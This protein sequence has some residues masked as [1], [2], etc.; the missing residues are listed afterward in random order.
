VASPAI[1]TE[2]P[3]TSKNASKKNKKKDKK[4]VLLEAG[5]EEVG[6]SQGLP[7]EK[8]GASCQW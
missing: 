1:R 5:R 3:V 8:V 2:E 6:T 7:K 4:K